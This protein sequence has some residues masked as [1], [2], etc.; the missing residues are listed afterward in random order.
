M[1]A[2]TPIQVLLII[3]PG[4]NTLDLNGP[5]DI[6][7]NAYLRPDSG[8]SPLQMDAFEINIAAASPLTTSYE[9]VAIQRSISLSQA[10]ENVSHYDVLI[11]TGGLTAG[12]TPHFTFSDEVIL[13]IQKFSRLGY[14][15]RLGDLRIMMSICTGALFFGY[16]GI[17]TGVEATTHFKALYNLKEACQDY[18]IKVPGSKVTTVVPDP[19]DE[20]FRYVKI[21]ENTE[22]TARVISS[23]G[24]SCGLDATLYLVGLLLGRDLA[25][26]TAGMME[27]AWREM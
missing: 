17:F 16:A 14:S 27:Y 1:A 21:T 15:P 5:L 6:L 8:I 11:Q 2:E 23:G 26:G 25:V 13:L 19:P 4:F 22:G 7:R 9:G 12:I 3:Y 20:N 18:N 24:I 10:S